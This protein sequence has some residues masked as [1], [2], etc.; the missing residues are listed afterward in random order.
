MN[1]TYLIGG[2]GVVLIVLSLFFGLRRPNAE[3]V[4]ANEVLQ[5]SQEVAGPELQQV[6]A[7]GV[8]VYGGPLL[9]DDVWYV[10]IE[11]EERHLAVELVFDEESICVGSTASGTCVPDYFI[12][13]RPV[14]IEGYVDGDAMRV[15]EMTF[16]KP[17]Q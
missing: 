5:E 1:K 16:T 8:L 2:F 4:A 6:F 11:H 14:H 3:P 13:D 15:L 17:L 12:E 9:K 10:G 7:D